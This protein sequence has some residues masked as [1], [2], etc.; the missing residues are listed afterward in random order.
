MKQSI[1]T[2][3]TLQRVQFGK[4]KQRVINYTQ[5]RPVWVT[6]TKEIPLQCD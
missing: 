3:I 2:L 1:E 4:T 6:K 5:R